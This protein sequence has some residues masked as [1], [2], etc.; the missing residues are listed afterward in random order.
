MLIQG[1]YVFMRYMIRR[2]VKAADAKFAHHLNTN[3]YER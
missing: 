1:L 2:V 3:Y